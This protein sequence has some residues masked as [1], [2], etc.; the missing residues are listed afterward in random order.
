M[1]IFQRCWLLL[2]L[3]L[4]FRNSPGDCVSRVSVA[5]IRTDVEPRRIK[6]K[7]SSGAGQPLLETGRENSWGQGLSLWPIAAQSWVSVQ[8]YGAFHYKLE[9]RGSTKP[10]CADLN[11]A[12][13]QWQFFRHGLIPLIVQQGRVSAKHCKLFWV[14]KHFYPDESGLF[15]SH[16]ASYVGH[17]IVWWVWSWFES[18]AIAFTVKS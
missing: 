1:I 18:Y 6:E 15:H 4:I 14:M 17:W 5:G 11:T 8:S 3:S 16:N 7:D 10:E 2:S 12:E 9:V 13:W